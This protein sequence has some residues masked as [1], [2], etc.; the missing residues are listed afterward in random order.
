MIWGRSRSAFAGRV[1]ANKTQPSA[2][3]PERSRHLNGQL[4]TGAYAAHGAMSA[5]R[6]CLEEPERKKE[7]RSTS[8]GRIICCAVGHGGG[9]CLGRGQKLA[10]MM[11]WFEL[12]V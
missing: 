5:C 1:L 3:A 10:S 9:W 7:K 11:W 12:R 6:V 2:V 4:T 8:M